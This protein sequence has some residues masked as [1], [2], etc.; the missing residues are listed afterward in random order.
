[1]EIGPRSGGNL[2]PQA[3]KYYSNFDQIDHMI[4]GY[5]KESINFKKTTKEKFCS[6]YI[7]HSERKGYIKKIFFSSSIQKNI[8]AKYLWKKKGDLVYPFYNSSY[9]IGA[10]ILKFKNSD[11][12]MKKMKKISE[13]IKVKI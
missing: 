12:M 10:C 7:I 9:T 4:R 11:E 5:L 13:L 8:I 2:I 1:M 3:I 6:T